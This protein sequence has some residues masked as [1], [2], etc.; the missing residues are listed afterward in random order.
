MCAK[1]FFENFR[2]PQKYPTY[3]SIPKKYRHFFAPTEDG[4]GFVL[5]RVASHEDA[6]AFRV[7][8]MRNNPQYSF[9]HARIDDTPKDVHMLQREYAEMVNAM[10]EVHRETAVGEDGAN[11]DVM[12]WEIPYGDHV[13]SLTGYVDGI[14]EEP[15]NPRDGEFRGAVHFVIVQ[16]TYDGVPIA[17][18]DFEKC[19]YDFSPAI[20]AKLYNAAQAYDRANNKK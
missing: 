9:I 2:D 20:I 16:G 3:R 17:P 18:E 5:H 11:F 15:Q 7:K 14:S 12:T 4:T 8:N 10:H 19:E 1:N 6:T 13:F